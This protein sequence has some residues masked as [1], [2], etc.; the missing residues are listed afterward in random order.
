MKE[1]AKVLH[2]AP[3]FLYGGIERRLVDWYA[4]MDRD[5]IRFDVVKVTPNMPNPLVDEIRKLGGDVFSIAPLGPKSSIKHVKQMSE[6]LESGQYDV[7][8]SHGLSYGYFPLRKARQMGCLKRILHSRTT[9]NNPGEKMTA[10]KD[11]LAEQS[12]RY[13]TDFFACSK[14]AGESAFKGKYPFHVVNNGIFLEKYTFKMN[15]R[16]AVRARLKIGPS[17]T[18]GFVGRF[19]PPKNIPF[20]FHVFGQLHRVIPDCR[21]LIVGDTGDN[22]AIRDEASRIAADYGVTKNITYVGRQEDITPWL[23]A[24]DIFLLPSLFEGFGT[25]ALEAQ[26]NGLPCLLSET[27]PRSTQVSDLVRYLPINDSGA[28]VEAI[29]SWKELPRAGGNLARIAEAGFDVRTTAKWLQ[30]FYLSD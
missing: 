3:G 28:W 29:I 4:F 22:E 12:L 30:D 27:V 6:I 5:R 20:L 23:A 13:A 10:I 11:F 26:A 25:V 1:T 15:Q 8:H 7:I 9:G 14:E 17:L 19:S 2:I 21:L 18:I 16:T 24:M